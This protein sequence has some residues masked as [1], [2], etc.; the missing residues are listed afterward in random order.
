MLDIYAPAAGE[1]HPVVFWIHGGGWQRGD[2]TEMRMKPQA[3]VAKGYLFVPINYRFVPRVTLKEMA[4]DVA[5]A[6]N[7]VYRNVA[8]YGGNPNSIFVMGHSA[9]AQL[10]ALICTDDRYLKAEGLSLKIIKGCVPL[11][12]ATYYPSLEIDTHPAQEA[13]FRLKFPVG[14]EKELSSVLHVIRSKGLAQ[15]KGVPPFLIVHIV[16]NP[17]SGT[18]VQS[19]I[20]AQALQQAGIY[21]RLVAAEGKTHVTLNEDLGQAGDEATR[22]VFEFAAAQLPMPR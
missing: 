17:E 8:R 1:N 6:I 10:A 21:V 4:G 20:L 19:Q 16:G 7:W 14:T 5:K 3:F 9:G 12:G 15:E 2:K 13:S 22:E 18:A 11:D